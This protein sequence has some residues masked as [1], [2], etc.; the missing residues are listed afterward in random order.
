MS[1]PG[2]RNSPAACPYLVGIARKRV[3]QMRDDSPNQ[4]ISVSS[5]ETASSPRDASNC[6][7]QVRN[8]DPICDQ[9]LLPAR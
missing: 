8:S 4:A 7:A 5:A 6:A 2:P 3:S 1:V 9:H